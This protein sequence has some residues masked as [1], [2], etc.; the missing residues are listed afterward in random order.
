MR[1]LIG[2]PVDQFH[3]YAATWHR[4]GHYAMA[5]AAGGPKLASADHLCIHRMP[6]RMPVPASWNALADTAALRPCRPAPQCHHAAAS[7][8]A[9]CIFHIGSARRVALLRAHSK[10]LRALCYDPQA[11]L[12]LTASF[13]RS[14]KV[15]EA[16]AGPDEDRSAVAGA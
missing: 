11:N 5:G 3:Q 15:W 2:L 6:C 1:T 7:H 8:G 14:V 10:T 16:A 12:L 9:L 13:D 4:S